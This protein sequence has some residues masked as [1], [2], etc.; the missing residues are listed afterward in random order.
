MPGSDGSDGSPGSAGTSGTNNLRILV[1]PFGNRCRTD[2]NDEGTKCKK[3]KDFVKDCPGQLFSWKDRKCKD[4]CQS[5]DLVWIGG[6]CE[7]A[8]N[9]SAIDSS[10]CVPNNKMSRAILTRLSNTS[11]GA[12]RHFTDQIHVELAEANETFCISCQMIEFSPAQVSVTEAELTV[13]HNGERY[14]KPFYF[15]NS[16]NRTYYVCPSDDGQPDSYTILGSICLSVQHE[17]VANYTVIGI[18]LVL[19]MLMIVIYAIVPE[20]HNTPGFMVLSQVSYSAH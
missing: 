9:N 19:L 20:L 4:V 8:A 11:A 2:D 13:R 3:V 14:R 6:K 5:K 12:P 17:T 15:E 18:S 16:E 10:V 1:Q 7:N